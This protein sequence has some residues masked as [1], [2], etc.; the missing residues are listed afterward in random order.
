MLKHVVLMEFNRDAPADCAQRVIAALKALPGLI[1][2]IERLEVGI[3]T[4]GDPRCLDLG[5]IVRV[6]DKDAL[7]RYSDHPAHQQV[8]AD[9]V[10][11]YLER[12]VVVDFEF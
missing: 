10:R 4:V 3:D 2:E 9:I 6:K 12:A 8:L 7:Q 1:P 5:L 11:P